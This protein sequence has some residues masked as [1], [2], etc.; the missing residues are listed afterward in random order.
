MHLFEHVSDAR[1]GTLVH[2]YVVDVDAVAEALGVT[3]IDDMP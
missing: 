2:V 1:P 3:E